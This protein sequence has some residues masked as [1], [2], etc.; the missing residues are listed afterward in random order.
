MSSPVLEDI[1]SAYYPNISRTWSKQR[2]VVERMVTEWIYCEI[3]V[4]R[5]A[6][7]DRPCA[8][9]GAKKGAHEGCPVSVGPQGTLMTLNDIDDTK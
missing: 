6:V 8:Q 7:N 5:G 3:R 1:L 2:V 4:E 9:K